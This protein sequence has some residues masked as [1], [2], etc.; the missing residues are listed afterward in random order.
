MVGEF[1]RRTL[2]CDEDDINIS[3]KSHDSGAVMSS[4]WLVELYK[5]FSLVRIRSHPYVFS[6]C[7]A[8]CSYQEGHIILLVYLVEW[9][10]FPHLNI[11]N[12]MGFV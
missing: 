4:S 8:V 12:T 11:T 1:G 7:Q 6:V 9:S 10:M 2:A 5:Y 3:L